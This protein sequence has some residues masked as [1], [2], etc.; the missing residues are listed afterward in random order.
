MVN[1]DPM[2]GLPGT[3][4]RDTATVPRAGATVRS[5]HIEAIQDR[6]IAAI[7]RRPIADIRN[8]LVAI[9][10]G[11]IRLRRL[12]GRQATAVAAILTAVV[13]VTP[14][15]AEADTLPAVAAVIVAE[16]AGGNQRSEFLHNA[17][18]KGG[19]S[20]SRITN[21]YPYSSLPREPH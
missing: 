8:R 5:L 2:E 10:D 12:A 14:T 20:I 18:R 21:E 3:A 9:Q 4:L 11:R 6:P 13:V 17:A 19:V 1:R 7:Q 15:V 16:E